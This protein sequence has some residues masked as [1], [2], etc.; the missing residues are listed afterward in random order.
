LEDAS[1]ST[2]PTAVAQVLAYLAVILGLLVTPCAAKEPAL[3]IR[4]SP[5]SSSTYR[6][7]KEPRR[8]ATPRS[9][10]RV[11]K[12]N[13]P[14]GKQTQKLEE[15]GGRFTSERKAPYVKPPKR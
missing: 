1:P 4:K 10:E 7:W 9:V 5:F 13:P 11:I 14:I 12:R 8:D 6:V 2:L 3:T 15:Q